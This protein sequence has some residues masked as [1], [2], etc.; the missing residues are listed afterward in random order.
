MPPFSL[1]LLQ[2]VIGSSVTALGYR[3]YLLASATQPR[4]GLLD[5][6]DT[7]LFPDMPEQTWVHIRR[8]TAALLMATGLG[9]CVGTLF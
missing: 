9:I 8:A 6:L 2:I 4:K 7:A 1:A 5:Q 3:D